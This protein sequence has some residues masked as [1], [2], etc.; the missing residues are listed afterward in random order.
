MNCH[1]KFFTYENYP[2][3]YVMIHGGECTRCN[4]GEGVQ[5]EIL[6][7]ANGHWSGP[8]DH[9]QGA[10][11]YAIEAANDMPRE[12][13]QIRNCGFCHPDYRRN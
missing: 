13:T 7:G 12:N 11:D 6:D 9:Y 10:H 1:G 8:F 2:N 3:N 5:E 4:C